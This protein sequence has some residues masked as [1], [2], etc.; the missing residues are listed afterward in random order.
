MLTKVSIVR[1]IEPFLEE[2]GRNIMGFFKQNPTNDDVKAVLF[3]T[4]CSVTVPNILQFLMAHFKVPLI[5]L[6]FC[7][8][9]KVSATPAVVQLTVTLPNTPRLIVAGKYSIKFLM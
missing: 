5:N 6:V 2:H 4:D 8:F 9:F 1:K 3:K 7:A